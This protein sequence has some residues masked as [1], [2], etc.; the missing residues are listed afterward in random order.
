VLV[1]TLAAGT[2]LEAQVHE[3]SK[4]LDGV[5][6]A[7]TAKDEKGASEKTKSE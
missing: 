4:M 7:K 1:Q 6:R 3:L 2:E 5:S